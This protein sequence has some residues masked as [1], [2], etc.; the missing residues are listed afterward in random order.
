[1]QRDLPGH[2]VILDLPEERV[3]P[4]R[5][6]LLELREELV[7]VEV[8]DSLELKET[9]DL[10]EIS[11]HLELRVRLVRW[12]RT[13]SRERLEQP[14]S[15][16]SLVHK[17]TVACRARRAI[18]ASPDKSGQVVAQVSRARLGRRATRA[19]PGKLDPVELLALPVQPVHR[20]WL[21]T[22]DTPASRD[23][24]VRLDSLARQV[25][26]VTPGQLVTPAVPGLL[27]SKVNLVSRV[28][29]VS[30]ELLEHQVRLVLPVRP[31]QLVK[32]E[33]PDH[34]DLR[35]PRVRP[36]KRV[37]LDQR[38]PPETSEQLE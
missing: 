10:L 3:R 25:R 26:R 6:E 37:K 12:A 21:E 38:V 29:L 14:D 17:A 9:L 34:Q 1:M 5:P 23:R 20:V 4:D 19:S 30:L 2:R 8:R 31:V 28:N 15:P 22:P 13:A 7:T 18:R 36:D 32:L 16:V 33:I 24:R 11:V 27:G 35:V